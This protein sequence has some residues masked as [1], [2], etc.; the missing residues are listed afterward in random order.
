MNILQAKNEI[1][2]QLRR[3]YRRIHLVNMRLNRK[4]NDLYC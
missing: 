2:I 1:K 4:I 3:I